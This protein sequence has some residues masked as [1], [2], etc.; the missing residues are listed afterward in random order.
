MF[1]QKIKGTNKQQSIRIEASS[2]L[3]EDEIKRMRDEAKLHEEE[4][5]K[6]K[7]KADKMNAADSLIFQTEKQLKEFGD[8]LPGG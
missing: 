7:E 3:N 8:K 4:D 2:G 1:L 6:I 5:K